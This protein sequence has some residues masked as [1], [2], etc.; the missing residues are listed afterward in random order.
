MPRFTGTVKFFD[1]EKGYGFIRPDGG[2]D[3]VFVHRTSLRPPLEDLSKR[4]R[5]EYDLITAESGKGNGKKAA[6]VAKAG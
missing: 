6:D 5:V 2:G 1:D 3:E 4:D